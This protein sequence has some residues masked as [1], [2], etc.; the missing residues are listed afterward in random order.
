MVLSEYASLGRIRIQ[1]KNGSN[2]SLILVFTPLQ[3]DFEAFPIKAWSPFLFL[4]MWT[5]YGLTKAIWGQSESWYS[6]DLA[7]FYSATWD[8]YHFCHV[9]KYRLIWW[10]MRGH[11]KTRCAIWAEVPLYQPYPIWKRQLMQQREPSK[12]QE[13]GQARAVP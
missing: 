7:H 9:N 11:M 6:K 3:Y 5:W 12:D 13:P 2:S 8:P 1:C 10:R 4:Y